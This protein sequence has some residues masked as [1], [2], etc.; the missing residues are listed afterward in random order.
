MHLAWGTPLDGSA[1]SAQVDPYDKPHIPEKCR[2]GLAA[3][4]Q[5]KPLAAL[6]GDTSQILERLIKGERA[7]DIAKDLGV[8]HTKLYAW[9]LRHSPEEWKAISAGKALARIEQAEEDMD[10]ATDQVAVSKAR[11]S[12][13]MG[14]WALERVAR[15]LY[16]DN[17]AD[18]GGVTVQVLIAR[19]GAPN[20]TIE[21]G[22]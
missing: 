4:H 6:A 12:H 14:A 17:K 20:V 1:P 22:E 7:V 2:A 15:N 5:D 3:A 13:R 21:Q 8:H 10:A 11:E 18:A 19:D 16:G 9:L